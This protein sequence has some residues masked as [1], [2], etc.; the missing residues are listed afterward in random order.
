MERIP[1]PGEREEV[2]GQ[3]WAITGVPQ[4]T[5]H[6]APLWRASPLAHKLPLSVVE[7][8]GSREDPPQLTSGLISA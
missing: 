7:G 1:S 5:V 4:G 2:M 3:H 8:E 6:R